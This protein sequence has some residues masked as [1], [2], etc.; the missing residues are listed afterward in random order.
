L[1]SAI[2]VELLG[3]Q[4]KRHVQELKRRFRTTPEEPRGIVSGWVHSPILEKAADKMSDEQWLGAINKYKADD[5]EYS[6]SDHFKGGASE[7]AVMLKASVEKDPNRFANL[8]LRLP[9]GTNPVY[10]D[11]I[12]AGMKTSTN[13]LKFQVV[14]KVYAEFANEC[15]TA[16]ADL[17]GGIE[18]ELPD[19]TGRILAWFATEHPDP[20][21]ELSQQKTGS[22]DKFFAGDIYNHGINTTRGRAAGAIRDLI[23]KDPTY[24][25]RFRPALNRMVLDNSAAVLSCVASTLRAV[26]E[27]DPGLALV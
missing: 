5:R 25:E 22:G 10:Y 17:L 26:G 19:D 4:A 24:I 2:P 8:A 3:P 27:H 15:G 1:L 14:R 21:Q 12:L 9:A 18:E 6:Y 7:L 23:L 13:R 16:I 20:Q 11:Q